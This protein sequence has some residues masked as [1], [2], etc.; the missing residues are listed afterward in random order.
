MAN[1]Q[2][3]VKSA[4]YTLRG[5]SPSHGRTDIAVRDTMVITDE[6][7]ERGGTNQGASP[8]ETLFAALVGCTN[9]VSTRIAEHLGLKYEI[10][11][12]VC[13][14]EFDRRGVILEERIEVPFPKAK[15]TIDVITDATDEQIQTIKDKLQIYCPVAMVVRQSGTELTEEFKIT[16]P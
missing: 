8:T 11:E 2:V 12:I 1:A 9:N 6:P 4:H 16:R 10:N 15:L 13:E 5:T 3:H 14:V 7:L